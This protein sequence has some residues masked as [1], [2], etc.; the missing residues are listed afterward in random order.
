M[1]TPN[2]SSTPVAPA[3]LSTL[4]EV[5]ANGGKVPTR[6]VGS[7]ATRT[8]Y[9]SSIAGVVLD[10]NL[11][12][13][14]KIGGGTAT[15][16]AAA[17]NAVLATATASNPLRLV[18]DGPSA[19]GASLVLPA[20]ARVEISG[21]GWDTGFFVKSGSCAS[22]IKN[23]AN[24]NLAERQ[25]W[26]PPSSPQTIDGSN[27]TL[28]DFRINGNR[29]TYPT[30]NVNN[31]TGDGTLTGFTLAPDA[32]SLYPTAFWLSGIIL[33]GVEN[34]L[35]HH[36]WVYDAPA[37]AIN[38]YHCR[39]F[40]VTGNFRIESPSLAANTDGVHVN[41]GCQD[42]EVCFGW[43]STGDDPVGFNLW[44]GDGGAGSNLRAHHLTYH[45]CFS[46]GR[47]YGSPSATRRV[48]F[49]DIQGTTRNLGLIIGDGSASTNYENNRSIFIDN[50]DI[51]VTDP[52]INPAAMVLVNDHVA[53]L[54]ISRVKVIEPQVPGCLVKL[55]QTSDACVPVV[56][57]LRISGCEVHRNSSGS[58]DVPMID[59]LKGMI[60]TLTL[61]GFS[62]TDH[63]SF[64]AVDELIHVVSPAMIG[65]VFVECQDMA[66]FTA[67]CDDF[68]RIGSVAGP[69]CSGLALPDAAMA[70]GWPYLSADR[71][72]APAVR[73]GGTTWLY[74]ISQAGTI[75]DDTF[76]TGTA[77]ASI[78]GRVPSPVQ[79]G[80]DLWTAEDSTPPLV[81][82]SA[83]TGITGTAS[84][85]AIGYP[86][87]G[88]GADT[89]TLIAVQTSNA[90]DGLTVYLR[91]RPGPPFS[92][93]V[94]NFIW[95]SG[96]GN[97]SVQKYLSSVGPTD[98]QV[99][100]PGTFLPDTPYTFVMS[101]SSSSGSTTMT[102]RVNG[103]DI[104]S[105]GFALTD[106]D[107][108]PAGAFRIISG[109]SASGAMDI[110]RV[111]IT[112]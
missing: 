82:R 72:S 35:I 51:Q 23:F 39:K 57:S 58:A 42:G 1:P 111:L 96:T 37:Y 67:F 3:R 102:I 94:V 20:T 41:G 53:V 10:C 93:I 16:N 70:D 32:R 88:A 46:A 101:L 29:G 104:T 22:A 47:V 61:A 78:A 109:G 107:I 110:S 65:R 28:R 2:Q 30:G 105:G 60:E 9:A 97:V 31:G 44:E 52:T 74:N 100:S 76:A 83:G 36:V 81:R 45:Q 24:T 79:N 64:S 55:G 34:V 26:A 87:T 69:G 71:S 112:E 99:F 66:H 17:L 11:D 106:A 98:V 73:L 85:D 56:S 89:T 13:G 54:E 63:G 86:L 25:V 90:S 59:A 80:T 91:L 8:V 12:T 15:D 27:V 75:L 40:L 5:V 77:G 103:T 21:L 7:F 6:M 50:W 84:G 14:A 95:G 4:P 33:R 19:I 48:S 38:L 108:Q 68:S 92:L 18:I 49:T 62:I 43:I